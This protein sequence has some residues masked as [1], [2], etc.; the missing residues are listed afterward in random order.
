M[1]QALNPKNEFCQNQEF[2][3]DNVYPH[4]HCGKN[5][6]TYSVSGSNKDYLIQGTEYFCSRI[7]KALEKIAAL[8]NS[9]RKDEMGDVVSEVQ[10]A[11]CSEDPEM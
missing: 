8:P 3:P 11:G 1:I 9:E 4:V 7:D 2:V 10:T 6:M 5:F